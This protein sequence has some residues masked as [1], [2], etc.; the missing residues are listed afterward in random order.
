MIYLFVKTYWKQ[1][2]IVAVLAAAV[3]GGVVAWNVHG[4]R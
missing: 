3:T 1:L 2:L 4:D